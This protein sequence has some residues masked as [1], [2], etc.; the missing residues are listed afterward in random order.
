[1]PVLMLCKPLRRLSFDAVSRGQVGLGA[2][3]VLTAVLRQH[4]NAMASAAI[5]I[6]PRYKVLYLGIVLAML[7]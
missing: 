1:M 5:F 4:A 2:N 7:S 6:Q 3:H